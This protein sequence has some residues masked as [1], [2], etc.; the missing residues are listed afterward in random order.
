MVETV[1]ASDRWECFGSKPN[2]FCDARSEPPACLCICRPGESTLEMAMIA[3]ST[4]SQQVI[5]SP[6]DEAR[7]E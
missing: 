6:Q 4:G 5:E 1:V 3:V 2:V 7:H